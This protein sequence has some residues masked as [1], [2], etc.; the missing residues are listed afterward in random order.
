L[1]QIVSDMPDKVREIC[2]QLKEGSYTGELQFIGSG[3]H[4]LVYA[5]P[6][7]DD[8]VIKRFKASAIIAGYDRD[9]IPLLQLQGLSCVPVLYAYLEQRYVIMEKVTGKP[10][11]EY[12]ED[13]QNLP[14]DLITRIQT[15][16][17]EIAERKWTCPDLKVMEHIYWDSNLKTM[18]L[19]DYGVLDY[20][21]NVDVQSINRSIEVKMEG[22]SKQI[23]GRMKGK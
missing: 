2:E 5:F 10:L 12:I 23:H 21:E 22:I 13:P 17:L 3:S 8:I 1:L 6:E 14:S 19:I 16:L 15:S 18:K 7:T 4:G 9:H 11:G 20:W